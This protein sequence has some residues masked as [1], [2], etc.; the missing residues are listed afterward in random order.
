MAK[1]N[2]TIV[3][4]ITQ[5]QT[6]EGAK[7]GSAKKFLPGMEDELAAGFSQKELNAMVERGDITGNWKSTKNLKGNADAK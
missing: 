1:D 4:G 2:R 6:I 3:H 7:T 5:Y